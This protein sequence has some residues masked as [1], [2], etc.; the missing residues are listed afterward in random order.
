MVTM[1]D[2]WAR[3]LPRTPFASNHTT[4]HGM[5]IRKR[6]GADWP[7]CGQV[8]SIKQGPAKVPDWF[9]WSLV[10]S[11]LILAVLVILILRF[12]RDVDHHDRDD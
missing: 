7:V 9:L 4:K 3:T 5:S 6:S 10:V 2:A 11:G 8:F 1:S 12:S